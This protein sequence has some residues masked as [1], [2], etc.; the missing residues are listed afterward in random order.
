M[1]TENNKR[2]AQ[3]IFAALNDRDL[4]SVTSYFDPGACFYGWGPQ[5]LDVHGYT[6][7]MSELLAAFP[8][9]R[10]PIQ[11]VIAEGDRVVVRHELKG[12]HRGE[13]QGV[14]P[15]G[16][17]VCTD[18]IAIFRFEAGS[19]AEAWLNAD[20]LGLFQQIGAVPAPVE[21]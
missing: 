9:S 3:R 17:T 21:P 1:S 16:R 7:T 6:T 13:F 12:T 20:F 18:G 5:A 2:T 15:T 19:A 4:D 10:F 14:P 11:D 8:D